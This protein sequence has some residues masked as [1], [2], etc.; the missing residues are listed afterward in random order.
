MGLLRNLPT[1]PLTAQPH[2]GNKKQQRYVVPGG[3][4]PG[5]RDIPVAG[6][7]GLQLP[8]HLDN[9]RIANLKTL[10]DLASWCSLP[11]AQL[12]DRD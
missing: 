1:P 7:Q 11:S 9:R 3:P 4:Q 8:D 5:V 12:I 10:S 6:Q 2:H